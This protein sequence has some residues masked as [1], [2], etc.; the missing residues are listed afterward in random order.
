MHTTTG[1]TTFIV[2]IIQHC[3]HLSS[4]LTFW[5]RT[6]LWCHNSISPGSRTSS[7]VTLLKIV[8]TT[9]ECK[10]TKQ[11]NR[12]SCIMYHVSLGVGWAGNCS[13]SSIIWICILSVAGC[14]HQNV[15]LGPWMSLLISNKSINLK[16]GL[17]MGGIL[18]MAACCLPF[19]FFKCQNWR[20][21]EESKQLSLTYSTYMYIVFYKCQL[22]VTTVSWVIDFFWLPRHILI[23][24]W[25]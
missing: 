19:S 15:R 25:K 3:P 13:F 1:S 5:I 17:F 20:L 23:T 6:R 9:Q 2:Y 18:T 4:V 11:C 12:S 24:R 10:Y 14:F 21:K 22:K 7:V 16:S 8:A